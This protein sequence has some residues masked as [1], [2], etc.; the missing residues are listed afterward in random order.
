MV[1]RAIAER[2]GAPLAS[3][4]ANLSGHPAA[5]TAQQVGDHLN[6]KVH[7]ILDGGPAPLAQEST[8]VSFAESPPKMI[9]EGAITEVRLREVLGATVI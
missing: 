1:P 2:F 8:V 4:S 9:R 5:T 3:T 6:G 7:L